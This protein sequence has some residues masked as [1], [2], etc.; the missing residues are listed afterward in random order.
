MEQRINPDD[1]RVIATTRSNGEIVI[2]SK[3]VIGL[4]VAV[5]GGIATSGF[6]LGG[7]EALLTE[8]TALRKEL[9][10]HAE[11]DARKLASFES[12]I[13]NQLQATVERIN[14][15]CILRVERINETDRALKERVGYIEAIIKGMHDNGKRSR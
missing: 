13:E 6:S 8:V 3:A 11:N 10:V 5:I 9:V 2:N 15:E 7:K 14:S 4:F 1:Q 12:H